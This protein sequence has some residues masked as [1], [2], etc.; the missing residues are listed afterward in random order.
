MN[1]TNYD[2]GNSFSSCLNEACLVLNLTSEVGLFLLLAGYQEGILSDLWCD[3]KEYIH[4]RGMS[5]GIFVY[6]TKESK[7]GKQA[8]HA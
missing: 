6:P 2:F 8:N 3:V 1:V 4:N 7:G 5:L